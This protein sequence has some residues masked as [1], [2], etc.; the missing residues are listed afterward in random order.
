MKS[1]SQYF[2]QQVIKRSVVT[3]AGVSFIQL[4]KYLDQAVN[5]KGK[6]LVLKPGFNGK[7]RIGHEKQGKPSALF[8]WGLRKKLGS[9]G[10][11]TSRF[12][13]EV[14]ESG[15]WLKQ[16]DASSGVAKALR[17]IQ[18]GPANALLHGDPLHLAVKQLA[19]AERALMMRLE[20]TANVVDEMR[21]F[22]QDLRSAGPDLRSNY[23]EWNDHQDKAKALNGE[24]K[25]RMSSGSGGS[26]KDESALRRFVAKASAQMNLTEIQFLEKWLLNSAAP[27]SLND[28]TFEALLR[29]YEDLRIPARTAVPKAQEP[30]V[31]P[32]PQPLAK[33]STPPNTPA[34]QV[35]FQDKPT[36]HIAHGVTEAHRAVASARP[37]PVPVAAEPPSV[38]LV[39][40]AHTAAAMT[41]EHRFTPLER[42]MAEAVLEE[43]SRLFDPNKPMAQQLAVQASRFA[44][45]RLDPEVDELA[46]RSGESDLAYLVRFLSNTPALLMLAKHDQEA[47]LKSLDE[48][49]AA[50]RAV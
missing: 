23:P 31:S 38:A 20:M 30:G 29:C 2:R 12:F 18:Q 8:P 16:F 9:N 5:T 17:V 28:Q 27:Y 42:E 4:E 43:S 44:D 25:G 21:Q 39:K 13:N 47:L 35:R 46:L 7:L 48:A 34:K 49:F 3:S 36:V 1:I 15:N 19:A 32:Q 45:I 22:R 24:M 37:Q 26:A 10:S 50:E 6:P 14:L 33:P 41:I 11:G 40:W